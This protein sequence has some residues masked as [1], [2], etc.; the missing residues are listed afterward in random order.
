MSVLMV[1]ASPHS[2]LEAAGSSNK[3]PGETVVVRFAHFAGEVGVAFF[4]PVA[5]EH[6]LRGIPLECAAL[7][8]RD[9]NEVTDGRRAMSAF[10]RSGRV[11]PR[12]DAVK[13][14]AHVIIADFK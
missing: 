5:N 8:K 12:A 9:D 7:A 6:F 3:L 4:R 11:L 10:D 2:P 13:E 14:V 1:E